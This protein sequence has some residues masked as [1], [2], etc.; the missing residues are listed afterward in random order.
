LVAV[1]DGP[2]NPTE[3]FEPGHSRQSSIE[4]GFYRLRI[5]EISVHKEAEWRNSI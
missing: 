2:L 3:F 1:L 4:L 5:I